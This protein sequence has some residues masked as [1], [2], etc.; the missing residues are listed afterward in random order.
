MIKSPATTANSPPHV[1]AHAGPPGAVAPLPG[2]V[3]A[4]THYPFF[5]M[6]VVT[7]MELDGILPDHQT[8]LQQ[9]DLVPHDPETMTG[10]TMFISH[11]CTFT[12][13]HSQAVSAAAPPSS[14]SVQREPLRHRTEHTIPPCVPA[15]PFHH[16]FSPEN[17]SLTN[18]P[19]LLPSRRDEPRA[20]RRDGNAAQDAPDRLQAS[21]D[22]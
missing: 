3:P 7:F 13:L 1:G 16:I 21:T 20:R 2:F 5:V 4:K 6:S 12:T 14:N 8:M 15:L 18:T 22:G 9:G 11:Q 17:P 10:F 19:P